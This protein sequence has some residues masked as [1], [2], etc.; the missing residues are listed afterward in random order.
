VSARKLNVQNSGILL[1]FTGFAP[2]GLYNSRKLQKPTDKFLRNFWKVTTDW[3]TREMRERTFILSSGP[4]TGTEG[5][6]F[7]WHKSTK[8]HRFLC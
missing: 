3:A 1:W 6:V 7:G 8:M 2:V 4:L 5:V